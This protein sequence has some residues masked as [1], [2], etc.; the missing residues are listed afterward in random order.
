MSIHDWIK[1]QKHMPGFMRDFHNCKELFRSAHTWAKQ[2]PDDHYYMPWQTA[3]VYVIDVFLKFMAY[4]GYT[5]QKTRIKHDFHDIHDTIEHYEN[6]RKDAF[7][8]ALKQH[9]DEA[10][11]KRRKELEQESD[12]ESIPPCNY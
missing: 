12:A 11:E 3:Q 6:E 4:H 2:K 10:N 5:L 8:A 1:E 7:F 9:S